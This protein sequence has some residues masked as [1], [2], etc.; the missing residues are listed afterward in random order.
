MAKEKSGYIG[1]ISNN[2]AQKVEAP[3]K[4]AGKKPTSKV[5]KGTDL[6]A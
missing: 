2:A 4:P 3:I 1:K 6:R 5:K